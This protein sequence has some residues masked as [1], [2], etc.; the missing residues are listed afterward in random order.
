MSASGGRNS[1]TFENNKAI[2]ETI[3][4]GMINAPTKVAFETVLA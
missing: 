1:Q 4:S 3:L 2:G